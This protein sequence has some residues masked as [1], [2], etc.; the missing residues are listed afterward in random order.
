MPTNPSSDSVLLKRAP[1]FSGR[2]KKR[3]A[4]NLV[5]EFIARREQA[6]VR[7]LFGKL[8]WNSSFDYKRE[9]SRR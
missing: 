3:E 4:V 7:D 6:R 1:Q 5:T 8:R 9:R 2:R